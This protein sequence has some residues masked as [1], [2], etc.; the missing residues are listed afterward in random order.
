MKK[1]KISVAI[2]LGT[3]ILV[4]L[5]SCSKKP[6]EMSFAHDHFAITLPAGV[7]LS[8]KKLYNTGNCQNFATGPLTTLNPDL[9]DAQVCE[10]GTQVTDFYVVATKRPG[11]GYLKSPGMSPT[12]QTPSN[13]MMAWSQCRDAHIKDSHDVQVEGTAA[14]DF[15]LTSPMG[16][17]SGRVFTS[18]E[19]S[20][21]ALAIP[22]S[23]GT[24]PEEIAAFVTSLHPGRDSGH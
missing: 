4:S 5:A 14:M 22:K 3:T 10:G 21:L 2:F 17:G 9:M 24:K 18:D 1:T 8:C 13:M 7:E 12:P 11:Q 23:G 20:I 6:K 19:Y 16:A 15:D